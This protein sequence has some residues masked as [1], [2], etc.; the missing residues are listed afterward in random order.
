MDGNTWKIPYPLSY[1]NHIFEYGLGVL[2]DNDCISK[3]HYSNAVMK[4]NY[5]EL[6]HFAFNS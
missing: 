4:V 1:Y 5:G 2:L 6:H 3:W